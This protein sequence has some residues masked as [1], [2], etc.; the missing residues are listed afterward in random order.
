MI[1]AS[2][3]KN[4][5]GPAALLKDAAGADLTLPDP[6]T[7]PSWAPNDSNI[8]F[9]ADNNAL[10]AATKIGRSIAFTSRTGNL[11]LRTV[12]V[13]TGQVTTVA[14][15]ASGSRPAWSKRGVI[16]FQEQVLKVARDMAGFTPG[17]GEQLRRAL[18]AK[19]GIQ[20]YDQFKWAHDNRVWFSKAPSV[21][22]P[23][24]QAT[25]RLRPCRSA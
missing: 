7:M 10:P 9:I 8:A 12:D 20:T 22:A 4:I 3:F 16:L 25:G 14:P 24:L 11:G 19:P 1:E 15:D 5:Y 17:Q 21:A 18:G 23:T 13:T 6:A 2:D